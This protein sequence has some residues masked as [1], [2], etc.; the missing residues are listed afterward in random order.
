MEPGRLSG[1]IELDNVRFAYPTVVEQAGPGRRRAPNGAARPIPATCSAT[2]ALHTKPPEALRGI[3]L[4]DRARARPWRSSA[5][6]ARA[7]RRS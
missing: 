1:A 2:D 5:R 6:R 4:L 3:D 7:S